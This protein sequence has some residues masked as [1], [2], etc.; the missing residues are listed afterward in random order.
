MTYEWRSFLTICSNVLGAGDRL[1]YKSSSW[2]SWT[3]F[4][5]LQDDAGY[6][7][8]GIPDNQELLENRTADGGTWVQPFLYKDI[9]HV[10]IPATFVWETPANLPFECG[11]RSQNLPLLSE[12]LDEYSLV[13]RRTDLIVEVKLY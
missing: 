13:H 10:I 8:G 9:A 5:R 6:W 4:R 7:Q 12:K 2:C 1:A 3:T 11:S